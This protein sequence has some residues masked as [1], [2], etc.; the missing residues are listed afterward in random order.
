METNERLVKTKNKLQHGI[1]EIEKQIVSQNNQA[2]KTV[3]VK[4]ETLLLSGHKGVIKPPRFDGETLCVH[5][6]FRK[7][8]NV[9][10]WPSKNT[11][12]SALEYRYGRSYLKQIYESQLK[13]RLQGNWESL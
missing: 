10:E 13:T 12:V 11:I 5:D 6:K 9:M 1:Q 7:L 8:Q 4:S 2:V 3:G